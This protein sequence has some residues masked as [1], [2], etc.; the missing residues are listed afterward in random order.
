MWNDPGVVDHDGFL[1]SANT[2]GSLDGD[3]SCGRGPSAV[4][5]VVLTVGLTS[6][7]FE[8]FWKPFPVVLLAHAHCCWIV[9]ST[10]IVNHTLEHD[11]LE[12]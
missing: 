11:L 2:G 5:D 6:F 10:R 7:V 4:H 3:A 8:R 9:F 1:S 12:L